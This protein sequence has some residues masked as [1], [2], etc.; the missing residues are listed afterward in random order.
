MPITGIEEIQFAQ[1]T[2]ERGSLVSLD[3]QSGLPFDPLRVF[4]IFDCSPEA[5]RGGHAVSAEMVLLAIR[6]NVVLDVD[7][8]C[9]RARLTLDNPTHGVLVLPGVWIRLSQFAIGTVLLVASAERFANVKYFS[10]PQAVEADLSRA[11]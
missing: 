5:E 2:D 10:T 7:N 4:Y 6:G 8:G 1:H 9:Q 11:A 3:R